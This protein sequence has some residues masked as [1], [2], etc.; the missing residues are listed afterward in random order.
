MAFPPLPYVLLLPM[1]RTMTQLLRTPDYPSNRTHSVHWPHPKM[2]RSNNEIHHGMHMP[3]SKYPS[4][5]C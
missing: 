3:L 2:S 4:A 1:A 5:I